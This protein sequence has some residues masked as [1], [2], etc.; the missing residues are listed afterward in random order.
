LT[1]LLALL[2]LSP[3]NTARA[4]ET[5]TGG[6]AVVILT[7]TAPGDDGTNGIATQ[8]DLRYKVGSMVTESNFAQATT[9][10]GE[11]EPLPAGTTQSCTVTGLS[12]GT[13]YYFALKTADERGNWSAISNIAIRTPAIPTGVGDGA[14]AL[15]FS[16]PWPNP[17]R[18]NTASFS[19]GIPTETNVDI[20]AY[21]VTG[22]QVRVLSRGAHAPGE[23]T[24]VWDLRGNEG[25]R[26]ATG[27]YMV[28]A[29]IGDQVVHRRV[30]IEN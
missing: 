22:R 19:L 27:V 4:A 20:E 14:V 29:R 25:Q 28:R 2:I 24:L 12:Y 13:T 16:A 17:A 9:V 3:L 30:V 26:L 7:W 10:I 11:P 8:Y 15:K 21:D 23:S 5:S 1:C 18:G 6:T